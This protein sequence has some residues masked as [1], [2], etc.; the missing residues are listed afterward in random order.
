[1]KTYGILQPISALPSDYGIGDFGKHAYE[2]VDM[3]HAAQANIWQVLPL[4]PLGMGNSPYQPLSS[5]AGDEI[6]IDLEDLVKHELLQEDDLLDVVIEDSDF[7]DYEFTRKAKNALL[8][9]AFANFKNH[10]ALHQFEKDNP[11]VINYAAF[12]YFK[13]THHNL[14]WNKWGEF[15]KFN[16]HEVKKIS[17]END[18]KKHIFYQYV[19]FKQWEQLKIYANFKDVKIFGD[20]P[21]YVGY[22]SQDVWEAP[23]RYR[24]DENYDIELKAGV[25][26]DYFSE[27]GQLWGNPIY[28]WSYLKEEKYVFW[29]ERMKSATLMYDIVR[30]DHFRAFYDYWEIPATALTAS[31]GSWVKCHC[32]E[33]VNLLIKKF[34]KTEFIAEDLGEIGPEVIKLRKVNNLKG[35]LIEQFYFDGAEFNFPKDK[36]LVSYTGTHDNETIIGWYKSQPFLTRWKIKKALR[37]E[38][39]RNHS[40]HMDFINLV[41]ETKSQIC[42]IPT[43][44]LLGLG[45]N[46]RMNT[47][48][49]VGINNWSWKLKNFDSFHIQLDELIHVAYITNR[50]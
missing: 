18:Y 42:I 10:K 17:T 11:W 28:N 22:D 19:F 49:T 50:H 27:T 47:P 12:R 33:V 45:K 13:E 7:V 29:I 2:F 6:Y 39:F 44:D 46:A 40:T 26:P 8:N 32:S 43:Q 23:Q 38:H 30:I 25:P 1:M 34:P 41:M 36:D 31:E 48:Q 3:L 15:A 35:M 4:N 5:F 20:V 9:K 37:H 16:E 24:I 21:F 14:P